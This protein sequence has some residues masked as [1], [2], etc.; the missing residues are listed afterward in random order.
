MEVNSNHYEMKS[1]HFAGRKVVTLEDVEW[2][3]WRKRGGHFGGRGVVTLED[4]E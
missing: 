2:S 3:L 1:G 4:K